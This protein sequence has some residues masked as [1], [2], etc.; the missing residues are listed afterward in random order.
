[1]LVYDTPDFDPRYVSP[2]EKMEENNAYAEENR[3]LFND[4]G[5]FALNVMGSP[6]SG[7]TKL[8]ETMLPLLQQ[9]IRVAV[10]EGD[11]ATA[12][13]ARRIAGCGVSVVQINTGGE[14]H[15]DAQMINRVLPGFYLEDIDM[16]II[17]NVGSLISPAAFDLGADRR[18]VVMSVAEGEDKPSKY[19]TAFLHSQVAVVNKIDLLSVL[20]IDLDIMKKDITGIN[21]DIQVFATCCRQGEVLGVDAL[22]DHLVL[23][24]KEKIRD[25]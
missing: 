15:L 13:D 23:L 5:V 9:R 6:G 4:F 3:R 16:L 25:Q 22:A 2:Q 10:I 14:G 20:D 21:P 1:M 17:E 7:K 18:M 19:P 8:L 11:L 12:K 24:A